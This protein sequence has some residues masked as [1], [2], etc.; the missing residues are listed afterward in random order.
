MRGQRER[1]VDH[2]S[3]GP[4]GPVAYPDGSSWFV[5][6]LLQLQGGKVLRETWYFAEP[7]EAP[8]WRAAWVERTR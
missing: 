7:V 5:S 4:T 3:G 8:A 6:A 2:A 1:P